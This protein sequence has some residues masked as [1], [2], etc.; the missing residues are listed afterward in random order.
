MSA[1]PPVRLHP[2]LHVAH[3]G[4]KFGSATITSCPSSST[5]GVTYSLSVD[6]SISTRAFA[7]FP[8]TRREITPDLCVFSAPREAPSK[9][10][11]PRFLWNSQGFEFLLLH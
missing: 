2:L 1:H 5:H 4:A 10:E 7:R 6:T 11:R 8:H 3:I 9:S